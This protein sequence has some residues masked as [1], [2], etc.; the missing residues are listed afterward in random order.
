[1]KLLRATWT[2]IGLSLGRLFWSLNTLML[3]LPVCGL[4]PLV[5]W[6]GYRKETLGE[7]SFEEFSAEFVLGLFATFLIPIIS[8][9]YATT[10]LG[11][12]RE[13]RTLLFLLMRPVPRP[14]ILLAKLLATLPL[15]A[16][17]TVGSFFVYCQLSGD[18]GARAF[19]LY[20]GTVTLL[21]LTYT[22]LFH[23]FAVWFRHSTI[24]ALI[25]SLFMELLLGSMPG[26]IVMGDRR[27]VAAHRD[28]VLSAEGVSR[29]DVTGSS[30]PG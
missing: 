20:A 27:R 17:L 12:D 21:A 25:Y 5:W 8:L 9:A 2:L 1:M 24:V 11:G 4:M 15:V 10:S 23:L 28:R 18:L 26:I 6:L 29:S 16:G 14:V 3:L 7:G 19:P 13:D 30:R 22:C